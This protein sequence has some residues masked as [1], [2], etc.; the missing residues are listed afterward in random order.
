MS[1]FKKESK[2]LETLILNW[3]SRFPFD[4]QWRKKYNVPFGSQQHLDT[5]FINMKFDLAEDAVFERF[6]KEFLEDSK[7][8][9]GELFKASHLDENGEVTD[10]AFDALDLNEINNM[11]RERLGDGLE[12]I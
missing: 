11:D 5:D 4:R 7:R 2:T 6:K 12:R 9:K 3:N 1:L 8:E 10:E